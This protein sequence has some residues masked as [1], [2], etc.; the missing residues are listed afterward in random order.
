MLVVRG[1]AIV[2]LARELRYS[3]NHLGAVVAGKRTPTP[4]MVR[5]L[6]DALGVDESSLFETDD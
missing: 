6:A 1:V 2:D 4:R 5:E 3:P